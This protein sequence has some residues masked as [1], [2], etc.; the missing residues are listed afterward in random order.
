[1][2]RADKRIVTLPP[3]AGAYEPKSVDERGLWMMVDEEERTLRDSEFVVHDPTLNAY[4]RQILCRT[5]GA[6]RCAGV[7]L[8]IER[9][10]AFN[11]SMAPNGVMRVWTGLL[12]RTRSEAELAA[13]LGH[14]FAH[15]EERHSLAGFRNARTMT[16]LMAWAG[17]LGTTAT[18]FQS[19]ALGTMFAFDRSQEKA[20][21]IHGFQYVAASP[22][23][24]GAAADIWE[25]IMAEADATA[26]GRKRRSNRYDGV[27]FFASHPTELQRAAY[28]RALATKDGDDGMDGVAEYRTA[29]APWMGQFLADQIK[30]NDFGGTEYLLGE[31]AKDGW[32]PELLYA[33]AELFRLRGNPRDLITASGL[34]RDCIAKGSTAAEARRGLGLSLMRSQS[35]DEGRQALRDYLTMKPDASDAGMIHML[36]GTTQ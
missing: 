20:A 25:R 2:A 18:T 12:L 17:F 34:Y 16:D 15:F 19:A 33:R 23:R 14:E 5:V 8:Y 35:P 28:M 10:P 26:A 13:V 32:T 22:Y 21:D 29:L 9:V 27:G 36:I 4:V 7:R 31:L 24:P 30:L 1:M 6:E 3:Y 11:A